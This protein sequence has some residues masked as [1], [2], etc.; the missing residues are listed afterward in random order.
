[1]GKT[2]TLSKAITQLQGVA[3]YNPTRVIR[4]LDIMIAMANMSGITS[5]LVGIVASLSV[6]EGL[7][8]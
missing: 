2:G 8:R 3:I 1:V 7:R 4:S 5:T 6:L